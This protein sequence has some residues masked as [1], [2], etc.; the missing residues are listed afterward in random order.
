MSITDECEL[1]NGGRSPFSNV[2]RKW[3]RLGNQAPVSCG[4]GSS[5]L[6]VAISSLTP[7]SINTLLL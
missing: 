6:G 1:T 2:N 4:S 3:A 7:P 5:I